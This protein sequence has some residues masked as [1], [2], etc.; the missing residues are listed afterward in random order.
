[1]IE[2]GTAAPEVALGTFSLAAELRSGPV[3]LVLFKVSCPTCQFT[4]PFLERLFIRG[5]QVVGISQDDAQSTRE[6]A[7]YF[8]ITFPVLLDGPGY[9]V[10]NAYAISSVPS[11]FL[12]EPD[13]VVSLAG[14]GFH[15]DDLQKLGVRAG[16]SPFRESERIPAMR[17][18]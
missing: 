6:F 2:A 16:G 9:P 7:D 18:G 14:N 13:G 12:I 5:L 17:P 4:L 3:L 15:R 10:S 11:L 8:G 1:M